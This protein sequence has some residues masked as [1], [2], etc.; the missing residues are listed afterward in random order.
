MAIASSLKHNKTLI[1]LYLQGN[2][3]TNEGW[4]TLRNAIY[5]DTSLNAAAN[6]NHTCCIDFP[7][8]DDDDED[9]FLD[10]LEM[11]DSGDSDYCFIPKYVRQKKVYSLLSSRNRNCCNVEYLE[12]VPFEL[13]P[14]ML[15]SI[16]QY[17]KYYV[18]KNA[19]VQNSH[20]VK[21]LSIVYEMCRY[22]DES[23]AVY[24]TLST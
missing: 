15:R 16:Q 1:F 20:D 10:V 11:N 21:P 8:D 5:D 18:R 6:S 12:D 23:L 19:P 14:D 22:W 24:E 9:Q 4:M 13:L 3:V 17:S 2:D 7:S